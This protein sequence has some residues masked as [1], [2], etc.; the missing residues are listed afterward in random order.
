MK[1]AEQWLKEVHGNP[2]TGGYVF[3]ED[4]EEIQLDAW[5]KGMTDA[6][7]IAEKIAKTYSVHDHESCACNMAIGY[8]ISSIED[9]ADAKVFH[10]KGEKKP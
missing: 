9:T 3:V 7:D 2:I 6:A 4:I 5:K 8:V 10:A 1:T